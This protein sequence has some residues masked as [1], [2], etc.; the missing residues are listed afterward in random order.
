MLV[1]GVAWLSSSDGSKREV[2]VTNF[3][4]QTGREAS[5]DFWP[6]L[7]ETTKV[8]HR[9]FLISTSFIQYRIR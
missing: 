7:V 9:L 8:V 4:C 1:M 5:R 3:V 2:A 6:K